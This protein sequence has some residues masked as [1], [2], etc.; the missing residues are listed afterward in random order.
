MNHHVRRR[1]A[2][3]SNNS[4]DSPVANSRALRSLL[5]SRRSLV[6]L[7]TEAQ[8]PNEKWTLNTQKR[9]DPRRVNSTG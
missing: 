4:L 7:L 3:Y 8:L 9:R 2:V 6:V 1:F 5:S